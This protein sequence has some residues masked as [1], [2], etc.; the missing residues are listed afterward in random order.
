MRRLPILRACSARCTVCRTRSPRVAQE[1]V[2]IGIG[3]GLAFLPVYICED[4]KLV[5]KYAKAQHLDVKASYPALPRRRPDAGRARLRRHRHGA[6][7]HRAVARRVGAGQ[8]TAPQQIV[9]VSGITTMPLT[10]L[11]NRPNVTTIADLG[12]ADR[13]AMPTLTAPQ[14][15]LVG[16][17]GGRRLF[18]K[19]DRFDGQVVALSPADALERADRRDGLVT[20]YFASPP[21][22]QIALRDGKIHRHPQF[23]R[24]DRRQGVVPLMGA[25]RAYVEAHPQMPEVID[26]AMDE[27]ARIIRDD[28]RRAAQIYLTHEPSKAL[29]GAVIE[30]VLGEIKDEFGSADLRRADIRRFHGPARRTQKAAAELEGYRGAGA[31][32]FAEHVTA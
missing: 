4:L 13:I 28:P 16:D 27:A 23:G 26:K 14:M 29:S 2:K 10:L 8:R 31:V 12:P 30:A 7:W 15:Y 1:Q 25:T 24:R 11:S 6:V 9:A 22:T 5:E 18:G 32:E 21:F 17:A 3:F 19:Y 20:A